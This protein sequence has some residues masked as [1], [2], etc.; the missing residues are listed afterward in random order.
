MGVFNTVREE[1]PRIYVAC[2]AAYN[3]GILH[4]AWVDAAREAWEIWE[5]VRAMLAGSP[6]P[7]AEEWAIHDYE[8]FGGVRINEY[9]GF[10]TVAQ[11]AGFLAEHGAVGAAI[12]DHFNGDL[13]EAREALSDRYH[14]EFESL[15]D[16]MQEIGEQ[17][18][19]IP[20]SLRFYIDWEAMGRDAEMSGDLFTVSADSRAVHVFS[21]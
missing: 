18:I 3:N 14:G 1:Q 7:D 12:L 15:A 17:S 11:I 10:E 6:I 5:D 9:A 2:L 8:G 4:G 20:E 13:D 16:Y 19:A 21:A